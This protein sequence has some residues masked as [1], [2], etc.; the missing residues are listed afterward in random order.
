MASRS[1]SS[2][3]KSTK[4]AAKRGEVA[5]AVNQTSDVSADSDASE[6][7]TAASEPMPEVRLLGAL[8]PLAGR[9]ERIAINAYWRAAQREFAPGYE[10]DDWLA[11]ER[12]IDSTGSD[13][14]ERR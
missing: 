4:E 3:T 14:S 13:Q 12:E 6:N 9:E 10:L 7:T 2:S 11:A 1:R 8:H 5:R